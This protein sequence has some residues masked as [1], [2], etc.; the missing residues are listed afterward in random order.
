ML[1]SI[2]LL[3]A[4]NS[5]ISWILEKYTGSP[6]LQKNKEKFTKVGNEN[7]TKEAETIDTDILKLRPQVRFEIIEKWVKGPNSLVV[8]STIVCVWGWWWA[9]QAWSYGQYC[10]LGCNCR[11]ICRVYISRDKWKYNSSA[12][13]FWFAQTLCAVKRKS[14]QTNHVRIYCLIIQISHAIAMRRYFVVHA[15]YLFMM[16][17][18]NWGKDIHPVGYSKDK[19]WLRLN[20]GSSCGWVF[21]L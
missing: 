19:I 3:P 17:Y 11:K 2:C 7:Y 13:F 8:R 6:G 5:A 18:H 21:L 15:P 14:D 4:K 16:C 20:D 9:S 1:T 12:V 10:N